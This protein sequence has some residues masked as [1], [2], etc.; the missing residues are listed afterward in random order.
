MNYF[1]LSPA[2]RMSTGMIHTAIP[3]AED[4]I[5]YITQHKLFQHCFS[6]HRYNIANTES[7]SHT[8]MPQY[9]KV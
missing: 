9:N 4:R 8:I 6:P 2:P 7:V 5:L 1:N 3:I